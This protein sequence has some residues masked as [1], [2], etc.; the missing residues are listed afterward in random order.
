VPEPRRGDRVAYEVRTASGELV[1][2]SSLHNMS[3]ENR[4]VE[5]GS[6]FLRPEVRGTAVN[7][8]VK[9]LMMGHAFGCGALR[10]QLTADDRNQRSQRAVAKLGAVREGVLRSQLTTWT[11]DRR[12][13]VV[14]SCLADE[15]TRVRA[16]LLDRLSA[17]Y[18]PQRAL[19]L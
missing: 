11:G 14:F 17:A 13:T 7:P 10:V 1:G 8:E 3:Q 2:A 19:E 16:V 5:I 15:W 6:S 18:G 4:T 9:L 12:N